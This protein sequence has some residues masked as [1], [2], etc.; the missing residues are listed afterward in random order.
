VS[1]LF[2]LNLLLGTFNLIPVPPLDGGTGVTLL[3]GER[4][5]QAFLKFTHDQTFNM[6]GIVVAWVVFPRIFS[7][8]FRFAL[9]A[10]YPD[11]DYY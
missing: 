8:V 1:V 5:G 7:P 9:R 2:S 3:M 4:L 6:V 11:V 10:L